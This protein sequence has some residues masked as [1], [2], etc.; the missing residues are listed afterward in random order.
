[1]YREYLKEA[2]RCTIQALRDVRFYHPGVAAALQLDGPCIHRLQGAHLRS[3][4]L[5]TAQDILLVDGFQEARHCQWQEL[6]FYCG[7]SQRTLRAIPLGNILSSDEFGAVPLW[8]QALH[9]V[10]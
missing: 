4:P 6:V 5:T 3:I 8:L 10:G 1:M 9:K 7:D 2:S